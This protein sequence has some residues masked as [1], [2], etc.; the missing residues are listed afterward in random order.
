M[1]SVVIVDKTGNC[2]EKKIKNFDIENLY[3]C[4]KLR[5]KSSKFDYSRIAFYIFSQIAFNIEIYFFG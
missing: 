3:K 5:K 1:I 2:S 4:C